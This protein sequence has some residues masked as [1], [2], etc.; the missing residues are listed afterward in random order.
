MLSS[1]VVGICVKE[2]PP[3]LETKCQ[4]WSYL[5]TR[6]LS[7]FEDLASRVGFLEGWSTEERETA[8]TSRLALFERI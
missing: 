7:D 1:F 4:F 6:C 5:L 3:G 2:K 8:Q